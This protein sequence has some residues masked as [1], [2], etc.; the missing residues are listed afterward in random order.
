MNNTLKITLIVVAALFGAALLLAGGVFLGRNFLGRTFFAEGRFPFNH[1][2]RFAY[3]SDSFRQGPGMMGRGFFKQNDDFNQPSRPFGMGPGMMGQRYSR[4]YEDQTQPFRSFGMG[5]GMMGGMMG[6]G[7]STFTG[8]P[9]SIEEAKEAFDDFLAQLGD[10]DLVVHEVMV[11]DQN[12]YAVIQ[13]ESTGMYA[14]ELLADHATGAVFPEYGPN[15]MWNIKYGMMGG[16]RGN[17][18]PGTCC[19]GG[20]LPNADFE[21]ESMPITLEEAKTSAQAYL[22][23]NFPGATIAEDGYTFYGYYTFDYEVEG[24]M[25][26]M[27]SVNGY[28]SN[29]WPHIWHGDF[30]SV[31]EFD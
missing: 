4:Q 1:M 8:E 11:F 9:L 27:L 7:F 2:N 10:E 3:G 22:D 18:G 29:V 17:L 15:K 14:M 5:P 26:G 20:Y 28:N 24:E 6:R 16:R 30:I 13:E 21:F 25:A 19:Q 23:A 12:A 31:E